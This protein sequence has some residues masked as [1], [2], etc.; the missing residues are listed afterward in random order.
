MEEVRLPL[1]VVN[2]VAP[3]RICDNGGWTDT[4]FAGHGKVFNIGVS[5]YVEVQVRVQ[6]LAAVPNRILLDAE[7]YGERYAFEPGALPGRQPLLEATIDEV[8]VPDDISVEISIFS[9]APAGCSTGTSASV[10]VALVGALD[11]L[12]PGRLTPHQIASSAHRIEA[13]RL[14]IQS[15]I[16]DQLCAAFGGI[17]YIEIP[18][19][20]HA[21]VS[22]LV[23][24]DTV[25]WELERRLVLVFLGRAH[26]SS[27]VHARV[28]ASLELEGE[29]SPRLEA[30]RRSAEDARDA[31]LLGDLG[32]LGRAMIRNTESQGD[33][34]ASLVGKEA[35]VA[36]GVAAANGALGWKLNGA[37]GEGG[38]ISVLCGPGMREKQSLFHA[39]RE[40]DRRF[41][42]IPTHLSRYGLRVWQTEP[43]CG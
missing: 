6:P 7:N 36:I 9:E 25:W 32:A 40:A 23:V 28:I 38:S 2:A 18:A 16:Q 11:S 5:P 20:P 33:L 3:I 42:I 41:E 29:S 22:Q 12:T 4:W 34:H 27:E 39:L 13:H 35:Q 24:P 19:Y 14:G 26:V 31:V 30:L 21:S 17:N 37:G 43:T 1:R 10:T 8:G 15:G